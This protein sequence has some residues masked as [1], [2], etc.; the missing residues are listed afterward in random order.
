LSP[1]FSTVSSNKASANE[2]KVRGYF[3][4]ARK[5]ENGFWI[6]FS[7]IGNGIVIGK[8]SISHISSILRPHSFSSVLEEH[9]IEIM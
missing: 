7:K 5:P 8:A 9:A 4:V 3:T 6:V 2:F 1:E